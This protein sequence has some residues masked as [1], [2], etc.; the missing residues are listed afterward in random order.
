MGQVQRVASPGAVAKTDDFRGWME[1]AVAERL[2]GVVTKHLPADRLVR[3]ALAAW[4]T[5]PKLRACD[6]N[7]FLLALLRAGQLGLDPSGALGQAYLVPYGNKCQLLIG[8]RGLIALA[9]RSGEIETIEAHVVFQGDRFA[10]RL[11]LNPLLEHEP[12]RTGSTGRDRDD[13]VA[14]YAIARFKGGGYQIEVMFQQ[15]I[16]KIMEGTQGGGRSG[17]WKDHYPE[18]ARK[19]AVR[20]LAKFLPLN[21]ELATAIEYNDETEY[22]RRGPM[23]DLTPASP[24]DEY[25]ADNQPSNGGS[26]PIVAESLPVVVES[27]AA[28]IVDVPSGHSDYEQALL[29]LNHLKMSQYERY[30]TVVGRKN[31]FTADADTLKGWISAISADWAGDVQEEGDPRPPYEEPEPPVE[32]L[33]P[34]D[35]DVDV[36]AERAHLINSIRN[37]LQRSPGLAQHLGGKKAEDC[38]LDELHSIQDQI[39]R[40][41]ADGDGVSDL[42]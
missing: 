40:L 22:G 35:L 15:D 41:L 31:P 1:G 39:Y 25:H 6:R 42:E 13:V 5:N 9:R 7:S 21:A 27:Q 12:D 23:I 33:P 17:P 19:T 8:Y 36:E 24:D 14:A 20:R 28:V 38:S 26:P 16:I 34:E 2:R 4:S 29:H 32:A 37:E 18:M 30:K 10:Y 3:V 11:G